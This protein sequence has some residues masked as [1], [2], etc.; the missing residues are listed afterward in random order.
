MDTPIACTLTSSGLATQ[1]ER[2]RRLAALALIE[3][4]ETENGL[5]ITFRSSP[6]VEDELRALVAVERECCAWADWNVETTP[7]LVAL[8]V[9]S[10]GDGITTLHAMFTSL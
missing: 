5:R 4:I 6:D 2:W 1:S 7:E 10:T 3:R 8:D 9:R